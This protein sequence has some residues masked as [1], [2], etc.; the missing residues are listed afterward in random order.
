MTEKRYEK[1]SVI[2]EMESRQSIPG[3]DALPVL[4]RMEGIW[5]GGKDGHHLVYEEAQEDGEPVRCRLHIRSGQAELTRRGPVEAKLLFVPGQKTHTDYRTPYGTLGLSILT[6]E[7]ML[8][9]DES[10]LCV[11][12]VYRMSAG[13]GE[14]ADCSVRIR[15]KD[16]GRA[17]G[18]GGFFEG[19]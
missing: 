7:V 12:M 1:K 19:G 5:Y 9:T 15:V 4:L 16:S 2:I 3:V 18:D 17:A 6:E 11:E 10:A 13:E 14:P 8:E